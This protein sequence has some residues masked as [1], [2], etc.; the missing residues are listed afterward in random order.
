MEEDE[1]L[2]EKKRMEAK[3][4]EDILSQEQQRRKK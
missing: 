1:K 3:M 4:I 2:A